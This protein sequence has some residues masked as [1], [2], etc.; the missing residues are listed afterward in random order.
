MLLLDCLKPY[1]VVVV[2]AENASVSGLNEDRLV[3]VALW[4]TLSTCLLL[5]VA[6]RGCLHGRLVDAAG[7]PAGWAGLEGQTMTL[8]RAMAAAAAAGVAG[9]RGLRVKP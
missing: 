5:H 7:R 3:L 1:A 4:M 6:R 2:G 9:S 8:G